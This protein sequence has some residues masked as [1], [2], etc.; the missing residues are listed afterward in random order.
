MQ[1]VDGFLDSESEFAMATS[2]AAFY[3][4]SGQCLRDGGRLLCER[5]EPVNGV[6]FVRFIV[7]SGIRT[8][9]RLAF[10]QRTTS[11]CTRFFVSDSNPTKRRWSQMQMPI[12]RAI[13]RFCARYN[14][15]IIDHPACPGGGARALMSRRSGRVAQRQSFVSSPESHQNRG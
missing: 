6:S 5:F 1:S 12:L 7:A 14:E 13:S 15:N 11:P 2:R 9:I 3:F 8:E 4:R 10:V